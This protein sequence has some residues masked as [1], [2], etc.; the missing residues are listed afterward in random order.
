MVKTKASSHTHGSSEFWERPEFVRVVARER[1]AL[2]VKLRALRQ[3][4]GL[5]Q[6]RAAEAMGI[7]QV[8]VSRL[9]QGLHNPTF[10][11]LVAAATAYGVSL[12]SLF[13]PGET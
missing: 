2:G 7:H 9:E 1:R 3:G 12:A 8:H 10:S 4:K 11:V 5:T 13:E 6:E